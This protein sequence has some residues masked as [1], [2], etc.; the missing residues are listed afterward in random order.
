MKCSF[1]YNTDISRSVSQRIRRELDLSFSLHDFAFDSVYML[2][3]TM[4]RGYY[5]WYDMFVQGK[6]V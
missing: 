6:D 4:Y 1:N 2:I 3:I 5:I